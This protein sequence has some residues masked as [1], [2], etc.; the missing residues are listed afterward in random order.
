MHLD[1]YTRESQMFRQH[2]G[3]SLNSVAT[4]FDNIVSN[5]RS[6]GVLAFTAN[7]LARKLLYS[8]DESVWGVK[9]AALEESSDFATLTVEKL[10]SK[11]KTHANS[12]NPSSSSLALVS[13]SHGGSNFH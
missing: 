11:L 4:R 7:Q 6:C 5:L 9:I 1:T 10:Y 3:E 13:S 8:L 2:P 12:K